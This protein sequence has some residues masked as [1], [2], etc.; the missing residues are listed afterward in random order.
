MSRL[1]RA[2]AGLCVLVLLVAGGVSEGSSA[3]GELS[4]EVVGDQ[5]VVAQPFMVR[6][7]NSGDKRLTFCLGVCARNVV[8]GNNHPAPAFAVQTRTRKKWS[9]EV[10]SCD[11]ASGAVSNIVHGGEVQ[12]FSIK[13]LDPGTY[14]LLLAYKD[15]SVE[16][17]GAHCEA[18]WDG[19]AVQQAKT[20]PFD[21]VP[22]PKR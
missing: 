10:W 7:R 15:V 20:D 3:K 6:I 8:S 1:L 22:A 12:E 13:I 16:A 17:V 4:I 19:K 11:P 21:V 2:G 5:Q 14:R 18:M 9:K